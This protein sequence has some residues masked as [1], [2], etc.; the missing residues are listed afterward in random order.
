M[1]FYY[2]YLPS[3][4]V[5][6]DDSNAATQQKNEDTASYDAVGVAFLPMK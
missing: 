6:V 3:A 1:Y 5:A 2:M 4:S